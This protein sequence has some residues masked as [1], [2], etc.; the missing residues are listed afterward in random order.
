MNP[1]RQNR[2]ERVCETLLRLAQT[3]AATPEMVE[4]QLYQRFG[5]PPQ[6]LLAEL[7]PA[8]RQR[9]AAGFTRRGNGALLQWLA[10]QEPTPR[11]RTAGLDGSRK[12]DSLR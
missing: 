6:A 4:R 8:Q 7:T 5:Q 1:Y 11:Q 9:L 2:P 12:G 10:G 3:A